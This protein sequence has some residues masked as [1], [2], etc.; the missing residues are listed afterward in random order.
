MIYDVV[1]IGGGICGTSL[2]YELS[3]YNLKVLLA[4]KENDIS[5]G[6][7]KANSGIIHAG[8]DPLPGSLMA[9]YNVEGN[10]IIKE[11][12]EKLDV[13][14]KQTGSLVIAFSEEDRNTLNKLYHRGQENAVPGLKIIEKNELFKME[15][16]ISP[17]AI[18]AL[19]APGAGVIAP[20]ELALALSEAAV[21]SG[22]ELALNCEILGITKQD[23]LFSLKTTK[24]NILSP[25]IINAAGVYADEIAKMAGDD[26]F[27][28]KPNRGEYFLM[29]TS[30]GEIVNSVIFQCPTEHGKGVLVSPTSHGTL[31]VGPNSETIDDKEDISTTFNGHCEVQGLAL[32]S[33]PS[34]D[35]RQSIRNFAGLRAVAN[36]DDFIVGE[37]A[38]TK[39]FYNI[40]GIRSPGLTAAPAI[41]KD[42]VKM[43]SKS[44]L[45][46]EE[47][48]NFVSTRKFTVFSRLSKEEKAEII[49]KN[50]RYGTIVCR[51]FTVTEG[52]ITDALHRPVPPVSID[53]IKRRCGAGMGRCQGGFCGPK[54]QAIIARELG[55]KEEDVMLDRKGTFIISG[56][57][58]EPQE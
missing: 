24:G 46:L 49:R 37:S 30:Q 12:C 23:G 57:T 32:K 20:W 39:G 50:P 36:Q 21:E 26:S 11:L 13:E 25:Y 2:F 19:Y 1:I 28:I 54:V 22:M 8:Y 47:N 17:D 53:G 14:F 43:L 34:L 48:K 4:E 31:I 56:R 3:R 55:I 52:E 10:K 40:A 38:K 5:L 44:G 35:F 9:K 7:T 16:N 45:I 41:A 33:V 27:Y 15:P 29:D 58:K 51:C 18:C 42:I 6:T